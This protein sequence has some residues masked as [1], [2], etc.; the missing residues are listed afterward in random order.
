MCREAILKG[1]KVHPSFFQKA[2][3]N[4]VFSFFSG[5]N[6]LVFGFS[7]RLKSLKTRMRRAQC[8]PMPWRRDH[9]LLMIPI[10]PPHQGWMLVWGERNFPRL[11]FWAQF[12]G[13]AY[14]KQRIGACGNREFCAYVKQLHGLAASFGL[15]PWVLLVTRH[16]MRDQKRR[17]RQ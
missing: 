2:G 5:C 10:V 7:W 3:S 15:C 9:Y 4:H 14:H 6:H 1:K 11:K 12:H 17:I 13:S 16:S 8:L